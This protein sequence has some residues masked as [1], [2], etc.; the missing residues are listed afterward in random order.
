MPAPQTQLQ[1]LEPE[2]KAFYCTTLSVFKK[3][4][5]DVLIGGAYAFARYTG[6]ERHTKDL[7]V[8]VRERDFERTLAALAAAGYQTEVPFPHWLGKAHSGEYFVDVIY[9]SGNG[10][11]RMDDDWFE[12][13]ISDKVFDLPV[14]LCPAEE[15]MWSK[16]F[17]QERERYDGADVAHLLRARAEQIDWQRLLRRFGSN[18]RVL[19]SHLVLWLHLPERW[20]P[21][22]RLGHAG[23]D[24]TPRGLVQ[25]SHFWA[26]D[27]PRDCPVAPAIPGRRQRLG[28]PRRAR[29]AR[30]PDDRG[31]DPDLDGG[32]RAR[33]L[34]R[35][36]DWLRSGRA[37]ARGSRRRTGR[38]RR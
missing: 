5:L 10:I 18:W 9:S 33:R 15:M 36:V 26:A 3:A 7:D 17:I 8:F 30:Q 22:A 11:A 29:P 13:A 27:L 1:V 12:H 19:L 28:L 4:N 25:R 38:A 2:A 14:R 24:A 34:A 6:I 23:A 31:P 35:H 16:A 37:H 20:S 32:H 21:P